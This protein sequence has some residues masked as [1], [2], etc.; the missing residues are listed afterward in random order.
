MYTKNLTLA[1]PFIFNEAEP[2]SFLG[3]TL[4]LRIFARYISCSA[5]T[6]QF[7]TEAWTTFVQ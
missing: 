3:S 5:L 7:G 2:K 6:M 1:G 4:N